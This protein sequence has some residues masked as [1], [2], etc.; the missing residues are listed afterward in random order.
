MR[1]QDTNRILNE[2]RNAR[3]AHA[4]HSHEQEGGIMQKAW[5]AVASLPT[6]ISQMF[7]H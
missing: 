5:K 7:K 4:I 6:K 3:H 2:S 1:I